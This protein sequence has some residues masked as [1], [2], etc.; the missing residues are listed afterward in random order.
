MKHLVALLLLFLAACDVVV[1]PAPTGPT[2]DGEALVRSP[3]Q[4]TASFR[5]SVGRIEPIAEQ[6]CRD[7]N[8]AFPP[9][10]CDFDFRITA[11]PRLGKNAFQTIDRSGRPRVTFTLSLLQSLRND[12]EVAFILGHET[13]HQI[14]RHI[15]KSTAQ[16]RIGAALL[17]GLVASTG[18]ASSLDV[19]RAANLGA[20]IGSRAE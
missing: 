20:M 18:Q 15:Q 8:R 17:G 13:S 6:I 12:D 10:A 14:A 19:N 16:Q 11:D 1:S 3:A 4:A 9:I 2:G 7:Q 5:R